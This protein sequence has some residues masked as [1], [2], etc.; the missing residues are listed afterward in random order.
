MFFQNSRPF[1]PDSEPLGGYLFH[2]DWSPCADQKTDGTLVLI[3]TTNTWTG[4]SLLFS[5][6]AGTKRLTS[7]V[8]FERG[9]AVFG[10]NMLFL[11]EGEWRKRLCKIFLCLLEQNSRWVSLLCLGRTHISFIVPWLFLARVLTHLF[12]SSIDQRI[13]LDSLS[14]Q[15]RRTDWRLGFYSFSFHR[16]NTNFRSHTTC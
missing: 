9:W 6:W 13:T 15:K 5:A 8:L 10:S 14:A 11:C 16:S 12:H 1:L 3:G 7:R 2:L 4:G